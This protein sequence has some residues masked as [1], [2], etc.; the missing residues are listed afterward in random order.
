[1]SAILALSAMHYTYMKNN[2][3]L[4][5]MR[6]NNAR[7][8]MLCSPGDTAGGIGSNSLEAL[9]D[10]DTQ[11]ELDSISNNFQYMFA[12]SMLENIK[13]R[14]KEDSKSLNIFA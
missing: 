14:Q 1:M 8:G 10:L 13:K 11:L 6:I 5:M 9:C 3:E 7:M 12:K 4:N 2:A